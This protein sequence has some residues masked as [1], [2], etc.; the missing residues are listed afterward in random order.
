MANSR[1]NALFIILIA[2]ILFGAMSY[3]VTQSERGGKSVDSEKERVEAALIAEYASLLQQTVQ[4]MLLT[5]TSASNLNFSSSG[6]GRDAVFAPDGGGI[7]Y[8][9]PEGA[10]DMFF[11]TNV[12]IMGIGADTG[13]TADII[14]FVYD[15]PLARCKQLNKALTGSSGVPQITQAALDT[16]E[17]GNPVTITSTNCAGCVGTPALCITNKS[18]GAMY[19]NP[20]TPEITYA[21][22]MPPID[23]PDTPPLDILPAGG[24]SP[25]PTVY[26]YYQVLLER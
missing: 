15:L 18:G 19:K 12:G 7:P 6:T 17:A 24:G 14:L 10:T 26:L 1:G 9:M 11:R 25:P 13:T 16:I 2:V 4:R 23:L 20:L 8:K 21:G 3:A 22:F 5:G